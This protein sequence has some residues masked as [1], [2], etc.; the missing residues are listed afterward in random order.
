MA[1]ETRGSSCPIQLDDSFTSRASL[2]PQ[3]ARC[4]WLGTKLIFALE[5]G[6]RQVRGAEKWE[7][8]GELWENPLFVVNRHKQ[9]LALP[10]AVTQ[11]ESFDWL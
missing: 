9:V 3:Y 10:I 11:R 7:D 6:F 8:T 2:T 1:P 5:I 4:S